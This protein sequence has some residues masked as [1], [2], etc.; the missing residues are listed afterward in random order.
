MIIVCRI[1]SAFT[2]I[3]CPPV[4]LCMS[5]WDM[6]GREYGVHL[7]TPN[8]LK[9]EGSL[10]EQGFPEHRWGRGIRPEIHEAFSQGTMLAAAVPV[11]PRPLIRALEGF[12]IWRLMKEPQCLNVAY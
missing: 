12:A 11:S 1:S 10:K 9:V 2:P 3:L 5:E 6:S 8:N 4:R 7:R